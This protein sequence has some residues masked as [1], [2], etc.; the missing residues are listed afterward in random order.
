MF[1][2]QTDIGLIIELL[3]GRQLLSLYLLLQSKRLVLKIVSYLP[4]AWQFA[5]S[6]Q[7]L[8]SLLIERCWQTLQ[9]YMESIVQGEA[10]QPYHQ[11]MQS[12][13]Y[14]KILYFM[15]K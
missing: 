14:R 7:N 12:V 11:C 1:L 6:F 9:N 3:G 5:Q 4:K 15:Q 8:I 10:I 13:S 2:L